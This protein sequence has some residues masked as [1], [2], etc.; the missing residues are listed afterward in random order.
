MRNMTAIHSCPPY[1]PFTEPR[2]K[3]QI[4][5]WSLQL[6]VALPLICREFPAYFYEKKKIENLAHESA[7]SI[8]ALFVSWLFNP[9]DNF[10]I[11]VNL[12]VDRQSQ[13]FLIAKGSLV[14]YDASKYNK[15]ESR[16]ISAS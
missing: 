4:A 2:I 16:I 15:L 1:R 7:C 6:L 11:R 5:E 12:L 10:E 3:L 8:R 13:F 9:V 14:F